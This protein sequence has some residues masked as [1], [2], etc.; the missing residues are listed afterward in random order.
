MNTNLKTTIRE[1]RAASRTARR[2]HP[3]NVTPTIASDLLKSIT[4]L[5]IAVE[6]LARG[7]DYAEQRIE[8][9]TKD[10]K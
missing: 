4:R 5:V 6:T 9:L 3:E 2:I 8:H 7:L 1:A 10:S